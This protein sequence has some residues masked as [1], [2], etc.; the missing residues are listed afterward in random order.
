MTERESRR[1]GNNHGKADGSD[2]GTFS[3]TAATFAAFPFGIPERDRPHPGAGHAG[4]PRNP[5]N[6]STRRSQLRMAGNGSSEMPPSGA[7]AT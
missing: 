5:G 7:R 6:A 1:T 2:D 3:F 4:I